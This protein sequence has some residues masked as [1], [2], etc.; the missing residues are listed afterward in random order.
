[1][2]AALSKGLQIKLSVISGAN[3]IAERPAHLQN[4]A[5]SA[6]CTRIVQL[7]VDGSV[8]YRRLWV[9]VLMAT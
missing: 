9:S 2:S 5:S 7:L 8:P 6:S 1:M 3:V 4:L